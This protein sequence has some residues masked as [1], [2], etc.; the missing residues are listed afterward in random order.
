MCGSRK[1]WS[2][3]VTNDDQPCAGML[4]KRRSCSCWGQ[5]RQHSPKSTSRRCFRRQ[6][7]LIASGELQHYRPGPAVIDAPDGTGTAMKTKA[8]LQPCAVRSLWCLP[9]QLEA[10]AQATHGARVGATGN[11]G[12]CQ[13]RLR[14]RTSAL[15]RARLIGAKQPRQRLSA[16]RDRARVN[17]NRLCRCIGCVRPLRPR[18]N[19]P[20]LSTHR[21]LHVLLSRR[22]ANCRGVLCATH[23][24]ETAQRILGTRAHASPGSCAA[25]V[26]L[27][28][29]GRATRLATAKLHN[30]LIVPCAGALWCDIS[31]VRQGFCR[32][33]C[34]CCH[35][36]G[37]RAGTAQFVIASA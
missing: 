25:R 1:T 9:W 27:N 13:V 36:L 19:S 6:R 22:L 18:R 7:T 16:P 12:T 17:C 34:G 5:H 32:L 35:D 3:R 24:N 33:H 28:A 29:A 10:C 21:G 8:R 23:G 37:A 30:H 2:V 4:A 26:A 14:C 15:H 31:G 11:A 20:S